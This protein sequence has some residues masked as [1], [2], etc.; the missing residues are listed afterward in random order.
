MHSLSVFQPST[1]PRSST[2]TLPSSRPEGTPR[3]EGTVGKG[4]G[5]TMRFPPNFLFHS[6]LFC[7][8]LH[9]MVCT[10]PSFLPSTLLTFALGSVIGPLRFPLPSPCGLR[11]GVEHGGKGR[12][13]RKEREYYEKEPR[14]RYEHSRSFHIPSVPHSLHGSGPPEGVE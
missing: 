8:N 5:Q 4:C 3:N 12:R 14:K 13:D 10:A 1:H 9:L 6:C 2:P 7:F 11:K